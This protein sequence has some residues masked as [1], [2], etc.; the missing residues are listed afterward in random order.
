MSDLSQIAP[1]LPAHRP[2]P[3]EAFSRTERVI[4][5][6]R[7]LLA[8]GTVL[9]VGVDPGLPSYRPDL[10][11]AVLGAYAVFS[12]VVYFIVRRELMPRELVGPLSTGADVLWIAAITL[13]TERVAS[14]FFL[15][16]VFVISSASMRWGLIAGA[17]ITI[18]L[19]ALYPA[20][21]L[22]ANIWIDPGEFPFHRAHFLRPIYLVPLGYLLGYLGEHERRSKRKLAFML[23]LT[24]PFAGNAPI[25]RTMTRLMRRVL[26]HFAAERGLLVLRDPDSGRWFSWGLKRDGGRFAVGLRITD[27][28]P[29]PLPFLAPTEGVLANELRPGKASAL[30]YDIG[31]ATMQR[32]AIAPDVRLPGDA[33]AQAMLVAPIALQQEVRG[34]A[35]M[36]RETR[37]KF[38]RD[39][40]EFFLLLV[41]QVASALETRRLQ[42]KAEEVAVLEE[43][44]RI[45]R[46]L[47]DGF[48]QSLAGIDLRVQTCERLLERDPARLPRSLAELH[49][50]VDRGYREVRH[51][52]NVLRTASRPPE[53][54][55]TTLDRLATEFSTREGI[56]VH[57][58]RPS[59]DPRLPGTTVYELTQIV[60]EALRNAVRHGHATQAVVKLAARPEH[61]YLVVRDNGAGF[62]GTARPDEDGFLPPGMQPWSIRER[63][64]ALGG[65]LRVWSRPREGAEISLVL[66]TGTASTSTADSRR[67]P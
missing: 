37:R 55:G 28:D 18:L 38:T 65:E 16:N 32:R 12:G 19:A 7:V 13:F 64:A 33:A 44:A 40:L 22:S 56:R 46:D 49:H 25:G 41:G 5:L 6:C 24:A 45:A 14:P 39:D 67:Q 42:A 34:R 62:N 2:V 31:A 4:A 50:A 35:F 47:H 3:L 53:P 9:L 27:R 8:V 61:L 58:A 57:I 51:F 10:A 60:R 1:R 26:R 29:F 66:P 11:F 20:I 63:A 59:V 48:I 30:C 54:L 17:P 43:R 21:I 15:L 23:A 52:L 36:L